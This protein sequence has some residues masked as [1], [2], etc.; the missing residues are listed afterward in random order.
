MQK[1]PN[2]GLDFDALVEE[3]LKR[4][5]LMKDEAE[6]R[7][8]S[9]VFKA[10]EK[11]YES[12]TPY[13]RKILK[14]SLAILVEQLKNKM[15]S[16]RRGTAAVDAE[17]VYAR[18]KDADLEVIAVISLKV[19][20]DVL[21][22]E[23]HPSVVT[24]TQKVG[25]AIQA[26]LRLDYYHSV[27]PGLYGAVVRKFHSSSGTQQKLRHFTHVFNR[28]GLKWKAWGTVDTNKV[29]AWIVGV[30][31]SS[32]GWIE[33]KIEVKGK[34][35]KNAVVHYSPAFLQLRDA[36]L[37]QAHD[38]AFCKW[39]MVCPPLNWTNT[40][41]GGYL[42]EAVRQQEALVKSFSIHANA[43]Q[44]D[45]PLDFINNLQSQGYVINRQVYE[46]A[47]WCLENKREVGKFKV[48]GDAIFPT[49]PH[50]DASEE[51]IKE[52]KYLAKQAYDLQA[53]A[54][55]H[56]WR[57][58][59]TMYVASHYINEECWWVPWSYD[60]RGRVYPQTVGLTPQ[61]TDF[62]KSLFYFYE[63]GPVNEDWLLW[64]AAT[65]YGL[66]KK[67]HEER[68]AW[69]KANLELISRVA[70]D[71]IGSIF[72][73]K[74]ADEPWCFL[75]ACFDI[76]SCIVERSK[77]TSG[78]PIGIDATCSGIQHLSAMTLDKDA[79]ARVNL[80]PGNQPADGYKDV[81]EE[82]LQYIT[83]DSVKA[84]MDRKVTKKTVMTLPYGCTKHSSRDAIRQALHEKDVEIE[85][86]LLSNV[87]DA[88]YDKA[89]GTI[90]S[91]P[92]AV[93]RWLKASVKE[94]IDKQDY[95]RWTTPSGFVVSQD[96]RVPTTRRIKT[97]LLGETQTEFTIGNGF[98]GP[99]IQGHKSA[100]SPNLVHSWDASLLHLTFYEWD[101]PFVVIHDCAL[102]RSCD[103]DQMSID[104]R[105]HFA[106]MY[107]GMPLIDWALE[108]G[109][110]IPDGLI[111]EGGN[112]LDLDLVNQSQYFFC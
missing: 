111:K 108:V 22:S 86:G 102:G 94:L 69:G 93:M 52:Y 71:P 73:W 25:N 112:R 75:A 4:E 45:V 82:S 96:I 24:L 103:M 36:L 80:M 100:L 41:R 5:F 60:Y 31:S 55:R 16:L 54:A 63:E 44:G 19:I 7:L 49:K 29:G 88:I 33:K 21:G 14:A 92:V 87:T 101:K 79:G 34:T 57:T 8:D 30:I 43:P 12:S 99:D 83:F 32:T 77:L 13:G 42:S 40:E 67:S 110:D 62:D 6:Q 10:R 98:A 56:N 47:Q 17:A 74:D 65:T 84:V 70:T 20:M 61:G 66:D 51:T 35:R 2:D 81:A 85:V 91:G 109:I 64:H 105:L 106:E 9:R 18:L 11:M 90:F 59:E 37:E 50:P 39:P 15:T 23:A 53:Q 46:V 58:T 38:L 3:Q 68:I 28:E 1:P 97:R 27:D 89:V 72:E 95:I 107:K 78:L 26:Q 48:Y 104:I 76:H